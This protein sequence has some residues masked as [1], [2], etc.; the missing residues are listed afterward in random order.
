MQRSQFAGLH[1]APRRSSSGSIARACRRMP[2]SWR[3]MVEQPREAVAA[4]CAAPGGAGAPAVASSRP[5]LCRCRRQGRSGGPTGSWPTGTAVPARPRRCGPR[6]RAGSRCRSRSLPRRRFPVSTAAVARSRPP[7]EAAETGRAVRRGARK[8]RRLP[9][10]EACHGVVVAMA[11]GEGHRRPQPSPLRGAV[12]SSASSTLPCPRSELARPAASADLAHA[13][14]PSS[15]CPRFRPDRATAE[16]VLTDGASP[17]CGIGS[18]AP[19]ARATAV[20]DVGGSGGRPVAGRRSPA[21]RRAAVPVH[22]RFSF[23]GSSH[24][25]AA[26]QSLRLAAGPATSA[27]P[28]TASR[29]GKSII[30]DVRPSR[31]ASHCLMPW[32]GPATAAGGRVA[33]RCAVCRPRSRTALPASPTIR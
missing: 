28:S 20:R 12:R 10:P 9:W 4:P 24:P 5:R 23:I 3:A 32:A 7:L 27:G 11:T 2:A 22:G 16:I 1:G 31:V 17:G 18:A 30:P 29:W 15:A 21:V 19:L 8:A 6:D 33:A 25:V 13:T 26:R 14:P